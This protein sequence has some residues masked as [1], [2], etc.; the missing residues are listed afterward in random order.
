M[1]QEESNVNPFPFEFLRR[2]PAG[3]KPRFASLTEVRGPYY[4]VLG[5]RYLQDLLETMGPYIDSIKFSG[6]SFSLIPRKTLQEFIDLC[7]A[8]EVMVST[9][10]FVEHVLT[11]GR[12]A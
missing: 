12:D 5:K 2:N 1:E 9:G 10:G 3:T 4:T 11:L 8:H 6:G 7:H